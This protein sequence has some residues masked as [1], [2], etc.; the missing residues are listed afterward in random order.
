MQMHIHK[1]TLTFVCFNLYFYQVD[2]FGSYYLMDD[3]NIPSLLALPYLGYV[4]KDDPVYLRT[5]EF[6]LSSNNP[7]F[8]SGQAG[9][10][11]GSPHNSIGW[12]W[13]VR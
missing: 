10:G 2:G 12:I 13:P 6:L 8:F 11:I 9:E 7:Y 3:A 4:A 5:R 1:I